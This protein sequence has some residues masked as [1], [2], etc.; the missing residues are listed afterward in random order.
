MG[1]DNSPE[2]DIGALV[3]HLKELTEND[4]RAQ[5]TLLAGDARPE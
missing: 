3:N 1:Q 2:R 4:R 5:R